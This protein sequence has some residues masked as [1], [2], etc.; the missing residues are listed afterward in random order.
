MLCATKAFEAT[1]SSTQLAALQTY[2]DG[3]SR[4]TQ[5]SYTTNI[6][7][8]Y[9]SNL[10]SDCRAGI[11]RSSLSGTQATA[12]DTLASIALSAS[13]YEDWQGILAADDYLGTL[14]TGY[15]SG[16][17]HVAVLGS[18]SA[19][20]DTWTLMLGNH[21]M[22]FNVNFVNGTAYPFPHHV[23]V[24]PKSSFTVNSST[25]H[26]LADKAAA[27]LAIFYGNTNSLS[28]SQLSTAYLSGQTFG[29]VLVG[30]SLEKTTG[31]YST[32][33][34]TFPT[35]GVAQ[36][37]ADYR[38][39][40]VSTLSTT[41][42]ALVKAA[43][44]LFAAD[45]DSTTATN[46]YNDYTDSTAWASTYVAWS[47]PSSESYP[48]VDTNATYMRIDGP[49]VW[50]EIACQN[51]VVISGQTHYHMIYRDKKYD[52]GDRLGYTTDF[53]GS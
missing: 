14:T 18:P 11:A 22:A 24:E 43:I 45:Y 25:W 42:Q 30:P 8:T 20:T 28:S 6:L 3:T 31:S 51:G 35:G 1:L 41:Q 47:G 12:Y 53:S 50:I 23:G 39:I 17:A 4:C 7:K 33:M 46:L 44:E 32:V 37:N 36:G 52:Y 26:V 16:Y 15:G 19:A 29:D 48:N 49:R 13:G 2:S 10:P 40:N 9:W 38:G 21:H 34:P 27:V 5:S